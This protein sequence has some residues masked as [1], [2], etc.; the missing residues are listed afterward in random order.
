[1]ESGNIS[2]V[3]PSHQSG[4]VRIH[5]AIAV[6]AIFNRSGEKVL[7]LKFTFKD[8]EESIWPTI[9]PHDHE[10]TISLGQWACFFPYLEIFLK[11]TRDLAVVDPGEKDCQLMISAAMDKPS[12]F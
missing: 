7:D 4:T 5:Q 2:Q 1:M 12:E 10:L 11:G 6:R 8:I 9:M 3:G